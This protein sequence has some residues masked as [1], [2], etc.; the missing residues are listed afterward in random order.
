MHRPQRLTSHVTEGGGRSDGRLAASEIWL[1]GAT[2]PGGGT[3][4]GTMTGGAHSE[5]TWTVPGALVANLTGDTLTVAAVPEPGTL[6]TLL[7][8]LRLVG[9]AVRRCEAA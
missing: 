7:T 8:G 9:L 6:A 4:V 1:Q 2:A 3:L 5:Y